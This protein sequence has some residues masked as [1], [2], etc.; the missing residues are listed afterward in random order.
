MKNQ[1]SSINKSQE[2]VLKPVKKTYK[3]KFKTLSV[4]VKMPSN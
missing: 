1:A 3:K 2:K 4:T